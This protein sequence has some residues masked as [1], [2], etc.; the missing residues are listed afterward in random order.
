MSTPVLVSSC[1]LGLAT[2]YDGSDSDC[3]DLH[4]YLQRN[5]LQA[6]PVC[7]EQLA[8]LPTPRRKCWFTAGDGAGL[9][10]GEGQLC[11]EEGRNLGAAFLRGAEQVLKCATLTG[12]RTAILKQRSPSCGTR[13]I[14][15][16]GE[17]VQGLGATAAL[18]KS[19]G[20]RLLSEDDLSEESG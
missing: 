4:R 1:L 17:L 16:N 19:K 14:Y 13:R 12:C 5:D 10:Q 7:P 3:Q 20:F 9:L 8:G 6:I 2:R 15:R 18:L 11:D